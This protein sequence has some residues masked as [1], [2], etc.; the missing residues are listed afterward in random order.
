MVPQGREMDFV[1]ARGTEEVNRNEKRVVLIILWKPLVD[2][3]AENERQ[4]DGVML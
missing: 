4:T 1:K 3:G 2:A